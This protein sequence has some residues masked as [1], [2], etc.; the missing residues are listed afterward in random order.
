[1]GEKMRK[2]FLVGIILILSMIVF[3]PNLATLPTSANIDES[4]ILIP[5]EYIV[6]DPI[7]ITSNSDFESQGWPG[8]GTVVNPYVLENLTI[9]QQIQY[10]PC[11]EIKD[12]TAYYVIRNCYLDA[13]LDGNA[14]YIQNAGDGRIENCDII[15]DGFYISALYCV[16]SFHTVVNNCTVIGAAGFNDCDWSE[17]L[18]CR[19]EGTLQL[20][21]SPNALVDKCEIL[22]G[23]HEAADISG[24]NNCF[25]NCNITGTG[26]GWGLHLRGSGSGFHVANIS[27]YG[28]TRY[29]IRMSSI[30]DSVIENC[31][32]QDVAFDGAGILIDGDPS[33]RVT[34]RNNTIVDTGTGIMVDSAT[35]CTIVNNSIG[36]NNINAQDDGFNT[37]WDDG[38]KF[39]NLYSDY[40]GEGTYEI[41]GSAN[42][43]DH[44]PRIFDS[45]SSAIVGPDDFQYQYGT[46]NHRIT[47]KIIG[48]FSSSFEIFQ[49]ETRIDSGPCD[50]SDIEISVDGL[51]FGIYNFTLIVT[52]VSNDNS[53]NT[54]WVSVVDTIDPVVSNLQD[55]QFEIGST[56]QN[57]TW[58]LRD[59]NPSSY[60]ILVNSSVLMSGT[61]NSTGENITI[62][63][64]TLTVGI[65]NMTIIATD[66]AG[67]NASDVVIVTVLPESTTGITNTTTTTTNQTDD[68]QLQSIIV[69]G[70]GIGFGVVILWAIYAILKRPAR[71]E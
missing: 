29:G 67:N 51:D 62:S 42:S 53:S 70:V 4:S 56:G 59:T 43:V 39:G 26:S 47:W 41:D 69:L 27:V 20:V 21:S 30:R 68:S 36:W 34:L 10:D 12:T 45:I 49:N 63:L 6:H 3:S 66:I 17:V 2:S 9:T 14:V 23:F 57:L 65:H 40:S 60:E 38:A 13:P 24:D 8:N 16:D 18:N 52:D 11:I 71:Y 61:W 28:V 19:I 33:V 48:I 5:S 7:N 1:M 15:G 58:T 35:D 55:I 22:S 64:D 50:S 46:I 31:R 25:F 37:A 44:Y 32:I 54:V